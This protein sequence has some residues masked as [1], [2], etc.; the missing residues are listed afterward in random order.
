MHLQTAYIYTGRKMNENNI[1]RKIHKLRKINGMSQEELAFSLDVSRQTVSKW[2]TNINCPSSDYIKRICELFNVEADFLLSYD[3]DDPPK[4][5]TRREDTA[6]APAKSG[7]V[8]TVLLVILVIVLPFVFLGL[9]SLLTF[10]SIVLFSTNK[11]AYTVFYTN[12]P[13]DMSD[14]II[15]IIFSVVLI[16]VEILIIVLLVRRRKK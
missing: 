9:L 1:G 12:P 7:R 15:T 10:M 8:K 14:F 2:E 16:S 4:G 13:F 5:R 6:G 3:E 11:G